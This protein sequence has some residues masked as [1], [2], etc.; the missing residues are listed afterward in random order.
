MGLYAETDSGFLRSRGVDVG[1][2][3]VDV[4]FREKSLDDISSGSKDSPINV[5]PWHLQAWVK[6]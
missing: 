1:S 3:L 4:I 2:P 6:L 5:R